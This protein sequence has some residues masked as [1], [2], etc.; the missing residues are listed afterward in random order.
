MNQSLVTLSAFGDEIAD[1]LETQ[2]DVLASEQVFHLELRGAWGQNVLDL[3]DEQLQQA[4]NLLDERGFGVSAIGSP[5]GKSELSKPASFELERLDRAIAAAQALG[6]R[7][8]RVFS[9]YVTPDDAARQRDEVLKRMRMLAERAAA[10]SMTLVHENEKGIYGDTAERCHDLI[11]SVNSPALRQAFDPANFVQVGVKPMAEAWPLLADV[12]I[13]V[14]IKD[15]VFADGGVRPAGQ[16]DGALP[17]LLAAL[18]ERG[19]RGFLTLEP[20]L[21]VAGHSSG[22]SGPDG[23]RVAANALKALIEQQPGMTIVRER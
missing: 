21:K 7:F 17:E 6:T 20:H 1:D 10:A 19:Y 12:T 4:K 15:A 22:Y 11:T 3:S 16:G 14:H 23:M 2:L 5:I 9:F 13:H 8:I 18:V